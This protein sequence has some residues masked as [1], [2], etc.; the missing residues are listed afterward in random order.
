M[1]LN[2]TLKD[3]TSPGCLSPSFGSYTLTCVLPPQHVK[4][5]HWIPPELFMISPSPIPF[6]VVSVSC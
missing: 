6:F 5:L 2:T 4:V 3:M 1:A